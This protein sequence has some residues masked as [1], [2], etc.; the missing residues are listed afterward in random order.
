MFVGSRYE[1]CSWTWCRLFISSVCMLALC[2]CVTWCS[3][4]LLVLDM[5]YVLGLR[6]GYLYHL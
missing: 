6:V 2:V 3:I 4:C 5:R 1:V